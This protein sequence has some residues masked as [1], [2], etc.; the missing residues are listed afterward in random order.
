M[1]FPLFIAVTGWSLL[2]VGMIALSASPA[3][4]YDHRKNNPPPQAYV[5]GPA[6][7]MPKGHPPA[8]A[9]Q[10]G[11]GHA[12][13]KGKHKGHDHKFHAP[14]GHNQHGYHNYPQGKNSYGYFP[15]NNTGRDFKPW[16]SDR[17][18]QNALNTLIRESN[19]KQRQLREKAKADRARTEAQRMQHASSH[20]SSLERLNDRDKRRYSDYATLASRQNVR[21][22]DIRARLNQIDTNLEIQQLREQQALSRKIASL[23]DKYAARWQKKR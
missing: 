13:S 19:L 12:A 16:S 6:Y 14:K 1:K 7:A 4:S 10:K 17:S 21:D 18:Y 2:C 23:D 20:W 9:L 15:F 3:H 22:A 5:T 8:H 11:K